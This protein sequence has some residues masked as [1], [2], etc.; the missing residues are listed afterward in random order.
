M[1]CFVLRANGCMTLY[2]SQQTTI[3]LLNML[4]ATETHFPVQGQVIWWHQAVRIHELLGIVVNVG[5]S[6]HIPLSVNGLF[7]TIHHFIP[8]MVIYAWICVMFFLIDQ[9]WPHPWSFT[10]NTVPTQW[11]HSVRHLVNGSFRTLKE[12]YCTVQGHILWHSLRPYI[13][14]WY[15][16]NSFDILWS[17]AL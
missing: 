16:L 13:Y 1:T 6:K 12:R 3:M 15:P 7:Y 2:F 11:D 4:F 17:V 5:K 9:C 14:L 8:F 10:S